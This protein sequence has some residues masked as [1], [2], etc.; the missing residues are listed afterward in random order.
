[1]AEE[2]EE[3]DDDDVEGEEEDYELG[4]G[5]QG[6]GSGGFAGRFGLASSLGGHASEESIAGTPQRASVA[7]A[8]V[9]HPVLGPSTIFKQLQAAVSE[10]EAAAQE[11]RQAIRSPVR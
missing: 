1:V 5:D 3:D 4:E 8:P 2:E 6:E 7:L 11:G 9:A 10:M